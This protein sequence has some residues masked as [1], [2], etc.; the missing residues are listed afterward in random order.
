MPYNYAV[1]QGFHEAS[2][3][4]VRAVALT[5][6]CRYFATRDSAGRITL[7]TLDP[8]SSYVEL[9]GITQ[10]NYN[11][12]DKDNK[13]RLLGDGGWEDSRKTGAGWQASVTSFFIKNSEIPA[14]AECPIFTGDY[15]E[16]FKLIETARRNDDVEIYVEIL[17]ELGQANGNTGNWIY[18]FTGVNV[19]VQNLKPGVDPQGLTQITYD[20]IGRG[21]VITGLYDAGASPLSFGNLQSGLLTT[22]LAATGTRR[23]AVV[24]ADNA[25]AIVTTANLTATYTSDGTIALTQL[26]LGSSDG[27]GFR[28]E[29]ASSGVRVPATVTL[30]SNVVTIDPAATLAAGTIY[31]L[32]AVDGAIT[33]AVDA[34]GTASPTGVRRALQGFTTTFRTA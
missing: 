5:P 16:G 26:A 18:D 25:S 23:I 2:R 20:M 31:R 6:P 10:L 4:L 29:N 12:T 34:N 17:A 32:T 8:G 9:Q 3:T 19:S 1:G 33:Q 27:A 11:K 21:A 28:L 7:P 13:F 24:P 30:S 15:E 14:D 22:S